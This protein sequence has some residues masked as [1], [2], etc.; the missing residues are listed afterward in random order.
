MDAWL[1]P[2]SL[3]Q[4]RA[5]RRRLGAFGGGITRNAYASRLIERALDSE[6]ATV[7]DVR[8]DHRRRHAAGEKGKMA[9][10]GLD[11]SLQLPI[12]GPRATPVVAARVDTRATRA[13][14][15]AALPPGKD[16]LPG[17]SGTLP[18]GRTPLPPGRVTLP[19]GSDALPPGRDAIPRGRD[20]IPL[21]RVTLPPGRDA[22]PPGKD[23]LP[24]GS[25]TLPTIL[26][27]GVAGRATLPIVLATGVLP[28]GFC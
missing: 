19:P 8:V 3:C 7:Q 22:L 10:S 28:E 26:A 16:A 20:A 5:S 23:A 25:D 12:S 17:G 1:S 13:G 11:T 6:A 2:A 14:G 15:R 18:P 4:N 21:G 24:R 9:G 27:T